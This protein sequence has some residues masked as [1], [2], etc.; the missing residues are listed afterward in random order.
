MKNRILFSAIAAVLII[1]GLA[2]AQDTTLTI[3]NDGKVGIGTTTPATKLQ[4]SGG[5]IQFD[6]N[7]LF[8]AGLNDYFTYDNKPM[9]WLS[10]GWKPDSWFSYGYTMWIS[11]YGGIKFFT[12]GVQPAITVGYWGEVGIGCS[13]DQKLSV[14][15]NASKVGG[16]SW[17]T[18]SDV[19]MKKDIKPFDDG[20][21][22]LKQIN[23]VTF[24]YNGK[25]GYPTDKTYVGVI[26]QD[27]EQ[28]APY[29]VSSYRTKLNPDDTEETDVRQF[30]GSALIYIA[31]NAIQELDKKIEELYQLKSENENLSQ[32]LDELES[33]VKT[34][35]E[36]KNNSAGESMAELH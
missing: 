22:V 14:N 16:G 36:Q 2:F 20:L 15:G 21:S 3:T 26:A 6:G 31:V 4:V 12:G 29:T 34:L 7:C 19:R 25:L 30:D 27:I 18:F 13:P 17:A 23:P 28:I 35:A 32:R 10:L 24:R 33:I 5:D 11:G 1:G 9:A 8:G